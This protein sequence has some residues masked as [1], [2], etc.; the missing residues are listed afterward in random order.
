MRPPDHKI[1]P[2][3]DR[4]LTIDFGNE[5]SEEKNERAIAIAAYFE[6][7]P[8]EGF[9]E[10]IP[11][12]SSTTI[13]F[14]PFVVSQ[15]FSNLASPFETVRSFAKRAVASVSKSD[16]KIGREVEI[17]VRFTGED[18]DEVADFASI[19]RA[20]LVSVFTAVTY[21]VFMLGFLPGFAYMGTVD[22]GI[23]MPRRDQPRS[24]VPAGSVG[25][26]GSQTGIYPIQSPGGWRLIG[27]TEVSLFSPASKDP[28][29]F[30]PGDSVKFMSI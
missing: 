9:I 29:R 26:A 16:P 15:A 14:D 22:P 23:R 10:T 2:L 11:T 28:F 30:R 20:E 6:T 8:F 18:I 1:F 5:I 4:A 13:F 12:Y 24:A 19:S 25:I 21:R 3:G 7:H 17:P 27:Q